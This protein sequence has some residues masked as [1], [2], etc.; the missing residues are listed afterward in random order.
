[1]NKNLHK[2]NSNSGS[3]RFEVSLHDDFESSLL[4]RSHLHED[5]PFPALE[6]QHNFAMPLSPSPCT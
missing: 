5:K 4:T 3:P 6:L 2:P 1:M